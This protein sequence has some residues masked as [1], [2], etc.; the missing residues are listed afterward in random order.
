MIKPDILKP[1]ALSP[2][3]HKASPPW[4]SGRFVEYVVGGPS[5][6]KVLKNMTGASE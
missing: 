2:T 1:F 6:P 4:P 3:P 5:F